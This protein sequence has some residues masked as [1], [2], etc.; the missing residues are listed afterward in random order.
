MEENC[1]NPAEEEFKSV[2]QDHSYELIAPLGRGGYS[3]VYTVYS[4]QYRMD[5]VAKIIDITNNTKY[6]LVESFKSEIDALSRLNHQNIISFFD[7]FAT[8]N[9][10]FLILEYCPNGTLSDLLK[11]KGALPKDQ[12]Y[13]FSSQ[14]M[15]ALRY[16]HMKGIAHRDIKPSNIFIDKYDRVKLADFGFACLPSS[17]F[18]DTFVGSLA[19]SPLEILHL[20]PYDPIK[21]D[22]WSLGVTLY[23]LATGNYPFAPKSQTYIAMLIATREPDYPETLDPEFVEIL[24]K[25]L[26]IKPADR[27]SISEI[28]STPFFKDLETKSYEATARKNHRAKAITKRNSIEPL[29]SLTPRS[30]PL[31]LSSQLSAGS[32]LR[33]SSIRKNNSFSGNPSLWKAPTFSNSILE[34]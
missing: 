13:R 24:K 29:P 14:I 6:G 25:M 32:F 11:A 21:A 7:H 4:R 20:A 10:L 1:T 2:L 19:F 22:I 34:E 3:T 28:L 17:Q 12:L 5:F 31:K 23:L 16:C 9:Y 15:K 27:P 33:L 26:K 8:D 30:T 18:S